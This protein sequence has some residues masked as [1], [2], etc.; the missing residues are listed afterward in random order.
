MTQKDLA[1]LICVEKLIDDEDSPT[2][3]R[4]KRKWD[5]VNPSSDKTLEM[6]R[7]SEVVGASS[8][9]GLA[10]VTLPKLLPFPVP[11]STVAEVVDDTLEDAESRDEQRT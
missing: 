8:N 4:G 1:E 2:D 7:T 3:N 5:E 9:S 10:V 11:E 6:T